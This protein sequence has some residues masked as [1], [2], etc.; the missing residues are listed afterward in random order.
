MYVALSTLKGWSAATESGSIST[1]CE[2][3]LSAIF[4]Y[5]VEAET[6]L[7]NHQICIDQQNVIEK[8]Q[9]ILMM[10]DIYRCAQR[11][12]GPEDNITKTVVR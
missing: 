1:N 12:L 6:W 9:Q 8:S 5:H 4:Q 3:A 10:P 2:S 7:W 11:V